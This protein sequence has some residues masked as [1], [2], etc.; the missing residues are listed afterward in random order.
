VEDPCDVFEV[1]LAGAAVVTSADPEPPVVDFSGMSAPV[2]ATL[3]ADPGAAVVEASGVPETVV[4]T[5][6]QLG[7]VPMN[8]CVLEHVY[9]DD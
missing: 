6:W 3:A 4:A 7:G 1:P 9:I 2:V 5:A 8:V